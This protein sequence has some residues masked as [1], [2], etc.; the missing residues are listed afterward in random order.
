MQRILLRI[1]FL[2]GVTVRAAQRLQCRAQIG[3]KAADVV[4]FFLLERDEPADDRENVLDPVGKLVGQQ[5]ARIGCP[6]GI[7]YVGHCAEPADAG[8]VVHRDY[9]GNRPAPRAVVLLQLE[10]PLVRLFVGKRLVPF[11]EQR[12]VIVFMDHRA[13]VVGGF[14]IGSAHDFTEPC[15]DVIELPVRGDRKRDMRQAVDQ[16]FQPLFA[17]GNLC[18]LF[19]IFTP[20]A[21]PAHHGR[22]EYPQAIRLQLGQPL[23][24]RFRVD[25]AQRTKRG[26]FMRDQRG[27]GVKTDMRMANDQRVRFEPVIF[28]RIR[29]DHRFR[30]EHGMRA[31]RS[32]ARRFTLF[33]AGTGQKALAFRFDQADQRDR[34]IAQPRYV[35]GYFRKLGI[36]FQRVEAVCGQHGNARF[37]AAHR[38]CGGLTCGPRL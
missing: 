27:T 7:I 4:M 33:K 1:L 13:P 2:R 19:E 30:L 35:C 29:H 28:Q 18:S 36:V 9:V 11:G 26:A 5:F 23:G 20:V 38:W 31:E 32:R 14:R 24:A 12:L 16:R 22:G 3:G 37:F 15:V 34:S 17:F 10:V 6:V 25:Y 21:Q 8:I